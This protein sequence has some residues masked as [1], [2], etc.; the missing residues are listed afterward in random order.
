[1]AFERFDD[2][3]A[4]LILC[5][6]GTDSLEFISLAKKLAPK[7]N[8]NIT[9]LGQKSNMDEIYAQSSVIALISHFEA[10]PL[11]IIEAMSCGKPVIATNV[12]GVAELITNGVNGVLVR[13][14]C[15]DDIV[16][17]FKKFRNEDVRVEIGAKAKITYNERF[18]EDLMLK[19]ISKI[20]LT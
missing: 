6:G 5:G 13:Q 7:T 3:S 9:F 17:A 2:D 12:G 20:Y 19:S 4:K 8:K 18:T 11:S 15:V 14:G 10:L 16:A 1:L